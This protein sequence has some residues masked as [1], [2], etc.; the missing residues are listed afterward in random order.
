MFAP[1]EV[2]AG[3]VGAVQDVGEGADGVFALAE[4]VDAGGGSFVSCCY[5]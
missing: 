3:C 1:V 2:A 5:I 4:N